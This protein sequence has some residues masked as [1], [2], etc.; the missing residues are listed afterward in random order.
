MC[1]A[2][3][4]AC[5]ASLDFQKYCDPVMRVFLASSPG[6]EEAS[7]ITITVDGEDKARFDLAHVASKLGTDMKALK[8]L[9]DDKGDE[10]D[11]G[12]IDTTTRIQK[13]QLNTLIKNLMKLKSEG[14]LSV[15]I[16]DHA[17]VTEAKSFINLP[18]G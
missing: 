2:Q 8:D 3:D 15:S 7:P 6:T 13:E 9:I 11:A 14:I 5:I 4:D 12:V 18:L 10:Y 1:K 16:G 17:F